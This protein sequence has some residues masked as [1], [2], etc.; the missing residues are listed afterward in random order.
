MAKSISTQ[1]KLEGN[2]LALVLNE[3]A[4]RVNDG[5]DTGKS[6]LIN[7][8]LSELYERRIFDTI[9][10]PTPLNNKNWKKYVKKK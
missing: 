9:V 3:Q 6:R 4:R 1:V 8:L 5:K 2:A 7:I 10:E